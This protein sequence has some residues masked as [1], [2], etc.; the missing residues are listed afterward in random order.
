MVMLCGLL[1]LAGCGVDYEDVARSRQEHARENPGNIVVAAIKEPWSETYINGIRLAEKQLNERPPPDPRATQRSRLGMKVLVKSVGADLDA[2]HGTILDIAKDAKVSAVLGHTLADVA[3]PASAVYEASQVIFMPPFATVQGLTPPDSKFVFRMVPDAQTMAGQ[4]ASA[5]ELLGHKYIVLLYAQGDDSRELAFQLEAAASERD[6][7]FVH[8]HSFSARET[9]YRAL[10]AQFSNKPFDMV[11]LSAKPLPAARMARQLREMGV[12]VPVMGTEALNAAAFVREARTDGD[13]VIVPTVY[14]AWADTE[15]N[16]QFRTE[17]RALF[18]DW[19]DQAAAQGYDSLRLLADAIEQAGTA[20]PTRVS[21]ALHFMPYW[22]GVTGAHAFDSRGDVLRKK[23]FF[24]V[25][26]GGEW[27]FLPALHLPYFLQRFD[28]LAQ[29][30]SN[31]QGRRPMFAEQFS[32][33]LLPDDLRNLQLDFLHEILH[34]R[35]LGVIYGEE[36]PGTMPENVARMEALGK[37]RGFEVIA[38]GAALSGTDQRQTEKRLLECYGKLSVDVDA[39][40]VTGLDGLDK[41]ALVRLQR[42]LKDYK[43]PL[44]ALL[45]DAVVDEGT[46]IRV[47]RVG[48]KQNLGADDYLKLFSGILHGNKLYELAERLENLPVLE[49]DLKALNDYG[50]LR[51]GLLLGLAPELHLDRVAP[52]Q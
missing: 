20:L 52:K 21:S 35:R 11:F 15:V 1:T 33:N 31:R 26:R 49:V 23:Y 14:Q 5:A 29:D 10:I 3:I 6:M 38:C 22:T 2:A 45:G 7:V 27:H 18:G 4:I 17:Y 37:Q 32:K 12:K 36:K 47:G 28:L 34:F 48:D 8:R 39:L 19:P 30:G 40:N 42:P 43:I 51:S 24:Q 41:D 46:A 16:R 50:L 25:L 44:L 13:N 9:D